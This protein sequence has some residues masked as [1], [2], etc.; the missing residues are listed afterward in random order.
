LL[1]IL[2]LLLCA[3]VAAATLGVF[4]ATGVA[5]IPA[6]RAAR[7]AACELLAAR[8]DP[9]C[10]GT[11]LDLGCGFG[12]LAF[13]LARAFPGA[14]VV[15]W[16]L[17]PLPFVVARI[18]AA[19]RRNV[20]VR[21]GSFFGAPL[22]GAAAVACYLML[23]P[24]RRLDAKLTAEL[25]PGTPVVALGFFFRGRQPE[26]VRRTGG[27]FPLDVGVFRFGS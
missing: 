19:A 18:R 6:S 26:E 22:G 10:E 8:L 27:V 13:D 24:M 14:R 2:F 25:A 3:S 15:G 12:G 1:S 16:E 20:E 7:R 23:R 11:I 21:F 4:A 5:P 9:R 17:S